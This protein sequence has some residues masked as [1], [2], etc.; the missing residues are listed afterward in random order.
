VTLIRGTRLGPY[1][2]VALLGAGGMGEVYRARDTKLN[3]SVAL[4]IL[5]DAFVNDPSLRHSTIR[6]S[7]RFTGSRNRTASRSPDSRFVAF[8]AGG[9]LKKIDVASGQ[10]QTLC[11]VPLNVLGGSWNG[12]GVIIFGSNTGGVMRV[13][14]AGGEAV[15]VTGSARSPVVIEA[16]PAFLPDGR[17]F[18]YTHAERTSGQR[19][20]PAVLRCVRWLLGCQA[21]GTEPHTAENAR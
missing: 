3:R 1:E 7:R 17:H 16:F 11:D 5:P 19:G 4:K 6:P 13:S 12:D 21:R 20:Q 2:V 10:A 18:V 9:K 15:P 14:E 8:E